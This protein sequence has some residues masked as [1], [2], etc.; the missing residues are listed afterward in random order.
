MYLGIADPIVFIAYALSVISAI[1]CVIYGLR[2]W[3]D[4]D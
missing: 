1:W 4:T 2:H 3:N